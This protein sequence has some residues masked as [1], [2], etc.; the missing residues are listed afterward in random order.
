MFLPHD[1]G[2]RLQIQHGRLLFLFW[3]ISQSCKWL[4]WLRGTLTQQMNCK[5]CNQAGAAG[6]LQKHIRAF[7]ILLLTVDVLLRYITTTRVSSVHVNYLLPPRLSTGRTSGPLWWWFSSR[8][9]TALTESRNNRVEITC[10]IN[11]SGTREAAIE[12]MCMGKFG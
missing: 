6:R 10:E 11:A 3:N 1:V 5:E 9:I 4:F 8:C 2:F 12:C 7:H